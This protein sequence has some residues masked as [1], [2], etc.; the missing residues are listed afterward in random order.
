[1]FR[2]LRFAVLTLVAGSLL[3]TPGPV[4]IGAQETPEAECP[5]TTAE[6]NE[7][8]ATMYWEEVWWGDQG[9]IAE[10][11]AEDEVHHWGIGGDSTGFEEF[12]ERWDQFFTAFPDL[13]F[14]VDLVAAEGDLAATRWTATGTHRGEWQGIAPTEREVTWQGINV[15]R[16]ECGQIVESWGE[17]DHLGLLSQLGATDIPALLAT[18]AAQ[19]EAAIPAPMA[20]PCADDSAEAN[21][22]TARRWTEEVYTGKD[23]AVLDEILD[24]AAIHHGAAFPDAVGVEAIKEALAG[25]FASFPDINLT[26]D[27]TIADGDLV[28]VRWSGTGTNDGPWLGMEPTGKSADFTGTNIYRFACGQIVESWSEMDALSV[29]RDLQ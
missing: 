12:S 24:P 11:V 27:A 22:A 18:P 5:V 25:T 7:A 17:A 1:M 14:T 3:M 8:L 6:E 28:V 21:V 19:A 15:F 10:I 26:V 20:T 4:A 2:F 13:E 16:F 29:L 23:L 9:K